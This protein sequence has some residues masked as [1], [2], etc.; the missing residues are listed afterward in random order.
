ASYMEGEVCLNKKQLFDLFLAQKKDLAETN[1]QML[2]HVMQLV[3]I[4]ME[5]GENVE[6]LDTLITS[7]QSYHKDDNNVSIEQKTE[8]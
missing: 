7:F 2:Y 6:H 4:I 8:I 5:Y 1:S 3:S